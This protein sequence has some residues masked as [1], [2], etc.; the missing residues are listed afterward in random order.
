MGDTTVPRGA[1]MK[2]GRVDGNLELH[3]GVQVEPEASSPIEVSGEVRCHGSAEFHGSL[4]CGEFYADEGKFHVRG[5]LKAQR[6][7]EVRHGD[8]M[9]DG[10]LEARSVEVDDRLEVRRDARA[11]EFEVGGHLEV[12][13]SITAESVDVGGFFRV[14]GAATVD[15]IDVGGMADV[16]G[17]VKTSSLDVGGSASVAGGEV[18]DSI[19]VGGSFTSSKPLKF[20]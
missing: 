7:I 11:D 12:A 18:S 3:E 19:D 9:V 20:R 5:D 16:K 6:D 1:T 10:S 14:G 15:R 4:A 13:G 8:L 2:I 17:T